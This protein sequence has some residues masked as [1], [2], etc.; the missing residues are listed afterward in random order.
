VDSAAEKSGNRRAVRN[1]PA[2]T[3]VAEWM[4]D[5]TGVGPSI[6]SGSQTWNGNMADLPQA[7]I[8]MQ[9]VARVSR[10]AENKP[11]PTTWFMAAAAVGELSTAKS[12]LPAAWPAISNPIR[13]K[14]SARRVRMKAF[15]LAA[16]A[17]G[18]VYQK[19]ISR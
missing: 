12:K 1:T 13:K 14:A 10:F 6:A 9:R 2:T 5:E 19:P 16:T 18:L 7:P 15:L 8:Y 3:M 11:V 4:S 17:D